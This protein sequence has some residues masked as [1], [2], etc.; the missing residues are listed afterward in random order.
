MPP[1]SRLKKSSS[2]TD[3]MFQFYLPMIGKIKS[4]NIHVPI[5]Q[6]LA[7]TLT[8]DFNIKTNCYFPIDCT[9]KLKIQYHGEERV[10]LTLKQDR[11]NL[12]WS[13][14]HENQ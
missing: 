4:Q 1:D 11:I 12:M 7:Q 2:D 3:L 14:A 10:T 5:S 8:N 13:H 6:D 9:I